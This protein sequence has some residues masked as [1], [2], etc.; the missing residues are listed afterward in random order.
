MAQS[1]LAVADSFA[2]IFAIMAYVIPATSSI[3]SRI[4]LTPVGEM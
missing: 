3:A 1:F 4:G 2:L